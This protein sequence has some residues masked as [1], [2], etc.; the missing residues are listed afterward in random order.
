[1]KN[2][3]LLA[4]IATASLTS[5]VNTSRAQVS[6]G[7]SFS[8]SQ[9]TPPEEDAG[10]TVPSFDDCYDSDF[11]DSACG[12]LQY[13]NT[14]TC[15][16]IWYGEADARE[17][18]RTLSLVPKSVSPSGIKNV[19]STSSP[20]SAMGKTFNPSAFRFTSQQAARQ[21]VGSSEE[22]INI[23]AVYDANGNQVESCRE[24][25]YENFYDVNVFQRATEGKSHSAR[26]LVDTAF[27]PSDKDSSVGTRH[28]NDQ[29]M[30]SKDG[31]AFGKLFSNTQVPKNA[32]FYL[33]QIPANDQGEV[34]TSA[35]GLRSSLYFHSFGGKL[36]LAALASIPQN[37]QTHLNSWARQKLLNNALSYDAPAQGINANLPFKVANPPKGPIALDDLPLLMP[38]SGVNGAPPRKYLDAELNQLYN[39]QRRYQ[40]LLNRWAKL[41][42]KFEGS[43]WEASSLAPVPNPP[44]NK[45]QLPLQGG[46]GGGGGPQVLAP[47]GLSLAEPGAYQVPEVVQR[48]AVIVE[49]IA[50]YGEAVGSQC[51]AEG[52][53]PCDWSPKQFADQV[54]WT[55]SEKQDRLLTRCDNFTGGQLSNLYNLDQ[56]F[57]DEVVEGESF[58]CAIQTD[59]SLTIA[60]ISKLQ[61]DVVECRERK[62]AYQIAKAEAEAA[63]AEKVR[64]EAEAEARQ[65]EELVDPQTGEVRG[66]RKFDRG[67]DDF[68]G[69]YFGLSY[70]YELGYAFS[71]DNE[72]CAIDAYAGGYFRGD[73]RVVGKKVSLLDG[74]AFFDTD[75]REA[76]AHLRILG[77][78]LFTPVSGSWEPTEAYEF[79][80]SNFIFKRKN[81][82][83]IKTT[84][85]IVVVP[86]KFELGITGMVGFNYGIFG[87]FVPPG[88]DECPSITIAGIAGP[89]L[90]VYGY[91]EAGVDLFI[92]G[93]GI[94]GSVEIISAGTLLKMGV[95]LA[96]DAGPDVM[97][98]PEA[99]SPLAL[100]LSI[101]TS[102]DTYIQSLSG[103]IEGYAYVGFCPLLCKEVS[104]EI[105]SWQ[106]PKWDSQVFFHDVDI[107]L[108]V[109]DLAVFGL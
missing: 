19:I 28:L 98:E 67:G 54:Q 90:G 107:N 34:V 69:Q 48:R 79:S 25:V 22:G 76:H 5:A 63:A 39:L 70:D 109:L 102:L 58:Y 96:L 30:R 40:R 97:G 2:R 32:F 46:G 72:V 1:M 99:E 56:V 16:D 36:V 73:A 24:L 93:A 60:D 75:M 74:Q 42:E 3:V 45:F 8:I 88:A 87:R 7:T 52:I 82:P 57:V 29:W 64:A 11:L 95:T 77:V 43:G 38:G 83:I 49:M 106:G 18:D 9:Q 12:Q 85:L 94:R 37:E 10:C 55:W 53:T 105:V 35:P 4:L 27:G 78:D 101:D 61:N 104:D 14:W 92:V 68:G 26:A 33:P 66:P 59:D 81:I 62:V 80:E 65:Y 47:G 84:I 51:I 41:N 13:D 21:T 15:Y 31:R 91:L 50:I 17:A 100:R 20:Q 86:V 71:F 44:P 6:P 103:I 89:L 23:Y 108:G